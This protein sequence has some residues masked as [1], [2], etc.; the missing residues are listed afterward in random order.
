[1]M[2]SFRILFSAWP[3]CV[4]PLAYGGPSWRTKGGS[5]FRRSSI[6]RY[7]SISSHRASVSGS[8]WERFA[9]I[10]KSVCGRFSV[11]L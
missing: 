4:W 9:R 8:R 5:P 6:A 11:F 1:M 7:R 3:M 10:G 2:M